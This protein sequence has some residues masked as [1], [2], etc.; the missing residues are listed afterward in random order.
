MSVNRRRPWQI[1]IDTGGTF[2]DCVALD[3]G[4]GAHSCKLLSSGAL[5]DRVDA[6]D[7]DGVVRLRGASDLPDGF[8]AGFRLSPLGGG[9]ETQGVDHD[10]ATGSIQVRRS[11]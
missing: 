6:T 4:G 7:E 9:A 8:L 5:R 11:G 3:P 10:A 1:W 2:T